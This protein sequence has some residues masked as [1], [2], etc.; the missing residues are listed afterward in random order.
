[1]LSASLL[2]PAALCLHRTLALIL[3]VPFL[4]LPWIFSS[5]CFSL[6]L[7]CHLYLPPNLFSLIFLFPFVSSPIFLALFPFFSHLFL[8]SFPAF[9]SV[10]LFSSFLHLSVSVPASFSYAVSWG[11]HKLT[12]IFKRTR[13]QGDSQ[14]GLQPTSIS[15]PPWS[16]S[17]GDVLRKYIKGL[18]HWQQAT[19]ICQGTSPEMMN[20]PI[21]Q[22]TIT[23][24]TFQ[25]CMSQCCRGVMDGGDPSPRWWPIPSTALILRLWFRGRAHTP[26]KMLPRLHTQ[27]KWS[28][29]FL[30]KGKV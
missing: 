27:Q 18:S 3:L 22:D 19:V 2:S 28:L 25:R 21:D 15:R 8:F 26:P 11:T 30:Q 29:S 5:S 17:V 12:W 6:F 20:I 4:L 23:L 10:S 13:T 14:K 9:L 24:I 1:M 16:P 7:L